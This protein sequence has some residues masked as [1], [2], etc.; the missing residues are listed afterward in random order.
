MARVGRWASALLLV[1][2]GLPSVADA[3][4]V[5]S[6][7]FGGGWFM[8][9]GLDSRAVGDVLVANLSQGDVLPDVSGSLDFAIKD[10]R[11]WTA[12]GEW[13]IAFGDRIEASAGVGYYIRTVPSRY[14]DLVNSDRGGA[15]IEQDLR[16]R[17]I[18]ITGLVR[19]LPFGKA[20]S[21]QPYVGGGI[22]AVNFRYTETGEFVDPTDLTI[23]C[24]G[25]PGC[26]NPRYLATGT[27][28]GPVILGGVRLPVNGDIYAFTIEG[29][30]QMVQG[31]TGGAVAGFLGDKI[32]LGGGTINFGVLIRF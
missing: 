7:Q 29:R 17:T 32:D 19:L 24:A 11:M 16:L 22:A 28:V 5:Q 10:F 14:R 30:Y 20:G 8:P 26:E 6:V 15:D 3:Q 4:V 9:K 2:L 13:N 27:A 21:V 23:F 18:P 25:T 31:K 12:F 1:L